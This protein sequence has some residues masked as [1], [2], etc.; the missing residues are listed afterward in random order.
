MFHSLCHGTFQLLNGILVLLNGCVDD[1]LVEAVRG[2]S[3]DGVRSVPHE[4]RVVPAA[5]ASLGRETDGRTVTSW[6]L[7]TTPEVLRVT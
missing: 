5:F 3:A 1:G 2:L 6:H 7:L 4:R